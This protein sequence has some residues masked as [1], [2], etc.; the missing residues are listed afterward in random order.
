M[1]FEFNEKRTIGVFH[2]C[3]ICIFRPPV[4]RDYQVCNAGGTWDYLVSPYG[5]ACNQSKIEALPVYV[6]FYSVKRLER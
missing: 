1:F 2:L 4:E 5:A 3:A 6:G